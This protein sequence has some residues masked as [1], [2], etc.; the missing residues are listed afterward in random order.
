MNSVVVAASEADCQSASDKFINGYLCLLRS[1]AT[2]AAAFPAV[3][4]YAASRLQHFAASPA[5]RSKD[6]ATGCPDL[7]ELLV[8]RLLGGEAALP[9]GGGFGE[10]F[11]EEAMVRN[12]R[13]FL[14]DHPELHL[15]GKARGASGGQQAVAGSR[16]PLTFRATAV[17]RRV[18]SFQCLF[19][20]LCQGLDLGS[21][22]DGD[23]PPALLGQLKGAYAAVAAQADWAAYRTL[24]GLRP[25][26]EKELEAA[27]VANIQS[28]KSRGYH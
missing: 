28:S 7:G 11:V 15:E 3:P 27:I 6:P 5:H 21:F 2:L 10:A 24:L 22:V 20:Q 12:V 25:L 1:L 16:G 14:R 4:A 23:C 8:L 19:A 26:P 9:W 17:S 18:V 13:W